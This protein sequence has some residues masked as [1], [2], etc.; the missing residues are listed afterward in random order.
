MNH[1]IDWTK[2]IGFKSQADAKKEQA[3]ALLDKIALAAASEDP[4][5]ELAILSND[6]IGMILAEFVTIDEKMIAMRNKTRALANEIEPVL[7]TGPSGTGKAIIARAL[8]GLKSDADFYTENCA[9]VPDNLIETELFGHVQGAFTGAIHERPGLLRAAGTGTVFLDEI[10]EA[11]ASL[12]AKLLNA[13]QPDYKGRRW[14]RQ[15]GSNRPQEIHCRIIAAT[16][17]NL[18]QMVKDGTFREDLFGRLMTWELHT[19]GLHDRP[20]DISVILKHFGIP[21]E[22]REKL[23]DHPWPEYIQHFNVR[24]LQAF[25]KRYH[26][27]LL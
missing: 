8:H 27:G 7:I 2:P 15:V 4:A 20:A 11:S 9:A 13:I 26:K 16:K 6:K 1:T 21:S 12:Q 17:R 22:E 10:G 25:A 19:T 3:Q 14:V 23:D 24:A 5:K 18:F